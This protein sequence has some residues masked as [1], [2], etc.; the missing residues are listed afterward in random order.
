MLCVFILPPSQCSCDDFD[1]Y[2]MGSDVMNG[3]VLHVPLIAGVVAALV[4]TFRVRGPF[5]AWFASLPGTIAHEL[6]HYLVALVTFSNPRPISLRLKRSS[7]GYQ[8][9]AVEFR[10][11]WPSA[12]MVALAPLYV[13]PAIAWILL[14]RLESAGAAQSAIV[15]YLSVILLRGAVPSRADW[16][17]ALR[18]PVGTLVVFASIG[19]VVVRHLTEKG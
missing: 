2:L 15:G 9:G 16:I 5:V 10:A 11:R 13:L 19:L 7:D 12:G 6:A 18:Y 3:F 14:Q 8:M 1:R 17:I 4:V